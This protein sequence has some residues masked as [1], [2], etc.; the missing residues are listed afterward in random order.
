MYEEYQQFLQNDEEDLQTLEKRIKVE[1]DYNLIRIMENK[2]KMD[3]EVYIMR[4]KLQERT[5]RM[6]ELQ[7]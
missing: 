3:K 1:I 6:R 4:K 2:L 5:E 7:V